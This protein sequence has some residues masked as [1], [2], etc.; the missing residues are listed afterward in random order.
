[1]KV[2]FREWF[3]LQEAKKKKMDGSGSATSSGGVSTGGSSGVTASN[4]DSGGDTGDS[5]D[6]GGDTEGSGGTD[7]D[8]IADVPLPLGRHSFGVLW[9]GAR[10]WRSKKKK[11]KYGRREDGK[12]R[13]HPKRKR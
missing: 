5:G 9:V 3:H 1:M 8:D 7:T 10:P 4:G 11:C 13:K 6:S 12:C 2:D